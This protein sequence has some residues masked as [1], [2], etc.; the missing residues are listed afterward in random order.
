LVTED[1]HDPLGMTIK[2]N[3]EFAANRHAVA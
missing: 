1:E 2:K 3:L